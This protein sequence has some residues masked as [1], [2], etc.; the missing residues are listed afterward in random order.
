MN[1]SS[2]GIPGYG[3]PPA[4]TVQITSDHSTKNATYRNINCKITWHITMMAE[5]RR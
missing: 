5:I 1:V 4:G 3:F 2:N